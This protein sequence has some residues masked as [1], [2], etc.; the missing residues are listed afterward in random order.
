MRCVFSESL[1]VQT[2]GVGAGGPPG[3][4]EQIRAESSW[5]AVVRVL[6][7]PARIGRGLLDDLVLLL[8]PAN[9]RACDGPLERASLIPVCEACVTNV[10][11]DTLVGCHRCGEAIDLDQDM[12]DIRFAA[13]LK[14]GLECH[15]CRLAAP[16]FTRAVSFGTYEGELRILV[17]LLKFSGVRPVARLV[18]S[19]LAE[20]ILQLEGLAAQDLM[21]VAVPLF[22]ARERQRGYNQSVLLA[23]AALR[24]LRRKKPDWR[25]VEAHGMLVRRKRTEAQWVLSP[26]GRRRNLRGSFQVVGDVKGREILLVDDILTSGATVRECARVLMAAGAEKVW[27]ATLARAQKKFV[28]RQQKDV[29]ELV[30]SWASQ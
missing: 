21:V 15:A 27:V 10:V 29:T 22:R 8:F 5:R 17:H 19:R 30:A 11:R 23:K 26:R 16:D 28:R 7:S 24:V 3:G 12:E 6:R 1:R 25:L 18:G 20:A 13:L 4:A 2:L 14:Q 9:C